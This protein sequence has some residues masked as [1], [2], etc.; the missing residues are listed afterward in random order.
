MRI[1]PLRPRLG[2]AGFRLTLPLIAHYYRQRSIFRSI[3]RFAL[4]RFAA[5]RA[6]LDRGETVY[7]AGIGAGTHNSGVALVEVTRQAGPKVIC[8]NEEERFSGE[9]H[10]TQF[11]QMAIDVLLRT[12]NGIGLGPERIDA[13]LGTFDY[14]AMH[15]TLI[16]T[17]LEEA[18]ASFAMFDGCR[19]ADAL[20][21]SSRSDGAYRP[22]SWAAV[23]SWRAGARDCDPASRQ[24]CLVLIR[25]LANGA[26]HAS[27]RGRSAGRAWRSR[28]YLDLSVRASQ[29]ASVAL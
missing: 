19:N 1:G 27:R 21:P 26:Q 28:R 2:A 16:R 23:R 10:S 22:T 15:A 8:N 24:S 5:L 7:L 25:G 11:P 29:H 18:P 3:S 14:P 17:L 4:K 20:P 13:W 9:K 12:M 6:K